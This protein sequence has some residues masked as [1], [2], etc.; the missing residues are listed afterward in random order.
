MS[1]WFDPFLKRMK[2]LLADKE[3]AFEASV[4]ASAFPVQIGTWDH[5]L[6]VDFDTWDQVTFDTW[7][8]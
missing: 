6:W 1:Q 7:D 3:T 8:R 2:T 5:F 4:K